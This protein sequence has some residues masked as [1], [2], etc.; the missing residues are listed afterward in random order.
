MEEYGGQ[1][2]GAEPMKPGALA[3]TGRANKA[4]H[5]GLN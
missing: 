3:G 4:A 2:A 5:I 1:S